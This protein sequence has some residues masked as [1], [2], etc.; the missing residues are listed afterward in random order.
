[1]FAKKNDPKCGEA[2]ARRLLLSENP[3][4]TSFLFPEALA[5]QG[6]ERKTI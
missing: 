3:T 4:A 6:S 5:Q 1:L 2:V